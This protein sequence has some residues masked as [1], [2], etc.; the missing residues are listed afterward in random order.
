[1]S[2]DKECKE[3][4]KTFLDDERLAMAQR[5]AQGQNICPS[6]MQEVEK[7]CVQE[8][9][10]HCRKILIESCSYCDFFQFLYM[11]IQQKLQG[12]LA[13]RWEDANIE[14][15]FSVPTTWKPVPTVE[16]FRSTIERAG[17]GRFPN[18]KAII[19][20]TEAEA[21]AV[22]TARMFPKLFNVKSVEP[23]QRDYTK[24]F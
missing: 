22:H 16:R 17:F 13:N 7:L 11:T 18:H 2:E 1:M 12:E 3:W 23:L 15:I 9:M 19:G 21:A 5:D 4:F 6:S 14:F 10:L 20:L 8:F 24:C